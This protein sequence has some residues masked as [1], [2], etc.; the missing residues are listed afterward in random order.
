MKKLSQDFSSEMRISLQPV[1]VALLLAACI[2][3][4]SAS[5]VVLDRT[6][7]MVFAGFL[8]IG[9]IVFWNLDGSAPLLARWLTLILILLSILAWG[10]WQQNPHFVY[11]YVVPVALTAA[12]INTRASV[13]CAFAASILT[14]GMAIFGTHFNLSI[15]RESVLVALLIV[16]GMVA[17][18]VAIYLPVEKLA[19]WAWH[20]YREAQISVEQARDS[21]AALAQ[22]VENLEYANRQL[23]LL[24]ERTTALRWVAEQ[25]Q[26]AKS[27]FV[28]RVS[29]EFRAPLNIIIG[30]VNLLVENPEVYPAP[31]QGKVREHLDIIYRNCQH[32]ASMINDVLALSQAQAGRITLHRS[33]VNLVDIIH[34]ASEIVTPLIQEKKLD[35]MLDLP[36]DLPLIYCDPTRIRQILLNLLSNAARLT[37]QGG[38]TVKASAD[39][40]TVT[41]SVEDTGP[42]ISPED[43]ERIFE[44]FFQGSVLP[45]RDNKGSGLGLSIS[46]QFVA[47]HG[48]RMW[49]ESEVGTGSTFYLELPI[50]PIPELT[51]SPTRWIR[52]DWEWYDRETRPTFSQTHYRPRFIVWHDSKEL[53]ERCAWVTDE[54][55]WIHVANQE[56]VAGEVARGTCRAVVVNTA[57]PEDVWTRV[58]QA[59]RLFPETVILGCS[60]T[61]PANPLLLAGAVDYL[62]KPL[63]HAQLAQLVESLDSPIHHVLVIDDDADTRALLVTYLELYDSSVHTHA[64]ATG[65][66]AFAVMAQQPV[67][68][69][70]LDLLLVEEHGYDILARMQADPALV[71]IPVIMITAQDASAR[72]ATSP[73]LMVSTAQGLHLDKLIDGV[74]VLTALMA[75]NT[76]Q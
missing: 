40:K 19:S 46:K 54:V 32:L 43:V 15:T 2:L 36:A 4:F 47:L 67:D 72:E 33:T 22:N 9:A 60:Y 14:V 34:N 1:L 65:K 69:V 35:F 3:L 25:A 51:S 37:Q 63:T 30:M 7:S 71:G 64:V 61:Q 57:V 27:A 23:A 75:R 38:I 41:L 59:Q 28:A 16:W 6:I 29:H 13:G 11:V 62:L 42:G 55:E 26:Q 50:E 10:I 5:D 76:Y 66:E 24:N 49:V 58:T 70:L 44:P 8:A 52:D 39:V 17:I 21:K 31:P 48:G 56:V 73:L 45:W 74:N 12:L 20:Y 68:L 53:A 18:L